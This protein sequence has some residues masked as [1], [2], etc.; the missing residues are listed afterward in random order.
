MTATV[1]EF[2]CPT[3]GRLLGEEEYKRSNANIDR[4]FE[5]KSQGLI[6]ELNYEHDKKIKEIQDKHTQDIENKVN[7]RIASITKEIQYENDK[8]KQEMEAWSK[9]QLKLK[10]YQ[11]QQAKLQNDIDIEQKIKQATEYND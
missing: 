7:Q 11:I 4:L 9:D 3:C 2:K 6:K 10:D 5:E 8:E 1:L